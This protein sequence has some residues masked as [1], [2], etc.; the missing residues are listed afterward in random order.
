MGLI[1][2]IYLHRIPDTID[3]VLTVQEYNPD[4]S[5]IEPKKLF[6]RLPFRTGQ[7]SLRHT[8]GWVSNGP[9]PKG[10]WWWWTD[11]ELQPGQSHPTGGG[12]GSFWNISSSKDER[13][14]IVNPKNPAQKRVDIGGHW[15]NAFKGS[16]GCPVGL[17]D[18]PERDKHLTA[19]FNWIRRQKA[20]KWIKFRVI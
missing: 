19:Y 3:A 8:D 17:W 16:L 6:D 15:E 12:I 2:T 10:D 1:H 5:D 14:Y 20:A 18:T 4:Q 11:R 13:R 7:Y 9:I